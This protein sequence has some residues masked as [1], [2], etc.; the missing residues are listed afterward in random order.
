MKFE[1]HYLEIKKTARFFTLGELTDKTLAVWFVL[2]G[3]GQLAEFF[4]KKFECI[5][6]ENN[7]IVAPEAL[8]KF[9]LKGFSGRV[10]ATWMTKEERLKE[11][12]D[13]ALYLDKVY[14]QIINN[15]KYEN[16]KINLLG[17]SQGAHTAVRW[18]IYGKPK[19]NNLILWSGSFP[20]E[21]EIEN[22]L[23]L[24]NGMNVFILSGSNDEFIDEKSVQIETERLNKLG[25]KFHSLRFDGGHEIKKET[26]QQ[27]NGML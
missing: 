4:I 23:P 25:L 20:A 13:Y 17:F 3:Y 1:K 11:I 12:K 18:A 6:G 5:A 16:I 26:L 8:N 22:H 19:I 10:G 15:Q 7:F 14:F 9:Y 2:H 24:F 21:P 27:L